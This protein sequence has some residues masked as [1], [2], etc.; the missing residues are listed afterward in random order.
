MRGYNGPG[1]GSDWAF[2][3]ALDPL[4]N[5]YVTGDGIGDNSKDFATIKYDREGNEIWVIRYNGP[6]NVP[7]GLPRLALDAVGNVYVAGVSFGNN[8]EEY[9][10]V[11]YVQAAPMVVNAG[12]DKMLYLGYDPACVSLSVTVSGGTA[13]YSYS[14]SAQNGNTSDISVCPGATTTYSITVTDATGQQVTDEVIINVIDVR[15]GNNNK[16]L[17]CHKGKTLCISAKGVAEHLD[18][19]DKLGWCVNERTTAENSRLVSDSKT[20]EKKLNGANKLKVHVAPNPVQHGTRIYYEL[21]VDGEVQIRILD[22]V[23]RVVSNLEQV[24]RKAGSYSREWNTNSF[25]EGVYYYQV[26]FTAKGE[27]TVETGKLLVVK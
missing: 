26:S 10:V 19:G 12:A 4:G 24:Y 9:A 20:G 27:A 18:H 17:V 22:A 2:A 3:I 15:C 25:G 23:G 14:W 8:G 13:P 16:V 6:N 21:A 5:V 1:N 11:K 7:D